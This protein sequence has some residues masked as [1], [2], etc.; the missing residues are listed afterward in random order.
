MRNQ[1]VFKQIIPAWEATIFFKSGPTTKGLRVKRFQKVN[2]S[3]HFGKFA[4]GPQKKSFF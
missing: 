4:V 2:C 1:I 3:I